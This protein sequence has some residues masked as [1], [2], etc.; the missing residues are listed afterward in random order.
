MKLSF[1]RKIN[2]EKFIFYNEKAVALNKAQSA[3]RVC[4][5]QLIKFSCTS[6][7]N[8]LRFYIVVEEL[9]CFFSL[10]S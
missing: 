5:W 8:L 2:N 3:G 6:Q 9:T 7:F 1:L 10:M 4:I